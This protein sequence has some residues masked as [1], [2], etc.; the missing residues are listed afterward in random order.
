MNHRFFKSIAIGILS[1][2]LFTAVGL[3]PAQA[4]DKSRF[5]TWL[6]FFSGLGS[7]AAG[8]VIKG[9]ASESYDAYLHTAVQADM[10]KHIDDYEQKR[11]QSIIASR[12]GVGLVI[13][14]IL[15]SLVDAAHIP[16]PQ[17]Q[18]P[19]AILGY[20]E[21]KSHDLPIYSTQSQNGD[22]SLSIGRRF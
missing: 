8:V 5:F 12:A 17:F 16:Q 13:G 20:D 10:E 6:M 18:K 7:S 3:Q 19:P 21:Y 1:V 4:F 9:Q 22:I 11:Q 2:F 14:A 15:I